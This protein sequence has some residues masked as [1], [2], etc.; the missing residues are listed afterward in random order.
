LS[1]AVDGEADFLSNA[2]RHRFPVFIDEGHWLP[3]VPAQQEAGENEDAGQQDGE[4]DELIW[5]LDS[6]AG[7]NG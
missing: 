6:G 1:Y 7:L 3:G 4:D 5:T 2:A